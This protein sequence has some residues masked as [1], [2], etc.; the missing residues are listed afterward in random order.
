MWEN[1][2]SSGARRVASILAIGVA[3]SVASNMGFAHARVSA[4]RVYARANMDLV[5]L[6]KIF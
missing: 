1:V 2:A 6:L 5:Y 3:S 4:S